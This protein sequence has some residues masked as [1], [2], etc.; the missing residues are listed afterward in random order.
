M[1]RP[2]RPS[3][4]KL[5]SCP[6]KSHRWKVRS[7]PAGNPAHRI[8]AISGCEAKIAQYA[9]DDR[10]FYAEPTATRRVSSTELYIKE[11]RR[12]EGYAVLAAQRPDALSANEADQARIVEMR[13]RMN[14]LNV[15]GS[16]HG[17]CHGTRKLWELPSRGGRSPFIIAQWRSLARCCHCGRTCDTRSR[18]CDRHRR[19]HPQ[20]TA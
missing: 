16:N 19:Q 20:G 3:A 8:R 6:P 10:E 12:L 9:G 18:R 7:G 4:S 2:T 17:K 5:A 11:R 15:A 1:K 13:I 14:S